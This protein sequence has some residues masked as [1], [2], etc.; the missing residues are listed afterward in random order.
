MLA[1][2]AVVAGRRAMHVA[3][4][5]APLGGKT[6][7]VTGSTSGIGQGVAKVLASR[8]AS[9]VLNGFGDAEPAIAAV[10]A[11]AAKAAA[12]GKV[13]FHP[14]DLTKEADI[15]ALAAAAV[16]DHHR[17]DVIV[18]NAGGV[19]LWLVTDTT[20]AA[21]PALPFVEMEVHM[22]AMCVITAL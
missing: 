12:G 11:V 1:S 15:Q 19:C 20:R 17:V 7:I 8:G 10:R 16:K 13:S 14:A 9:I 3:A 4:S 5:H 22:C 18:N 6:A 2:T 21:A